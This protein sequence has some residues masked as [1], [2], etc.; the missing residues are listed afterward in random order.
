VAVAGTD[1][2]LKDL[3]FTYLPPP[4]AA[5]VNSTTQTCCAQDALEKTS[6]MLG[7]AG[8]RRRLSTPDV[9]RTL[10]LSTLLY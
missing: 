8:R 7:G 3:P 10:N 1:M 2:V 9:L 6:C 5:T 4:W